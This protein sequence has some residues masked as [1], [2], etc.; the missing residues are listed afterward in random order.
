MRLWRWVKVVMGIAALLVAIAVAGVLF[1]READSKALA[2]LEAEI[3]QRGHPVTLDELAAR[4]PPIPEERNA[5][6]ALMDLWQRNDPVFWRAFRTGATQLPKDHTNTWDPS[7]PFLGAG[8]LRIPRSTVMDPDARRAA[9]VF[10]SEDPSRLAEVRAALARPECRFPVILTNGFGAL[11]PHLKSIRTEA[12]RLRIGVAVATDD[13]H[14]AMALDGMET[15][16]R[17]A[18]HLAGEPF[19][20]NQLVRIALLDGI[21]DDASRLLSHCDLDSDQL[22]TLAKVLGRIDIGGAL[23]DALIAEVPQGV[24]LFAPTMES[25]YGSPLL[26]GWVLDAI[27][28]KGAD[29]RLYLE[30]LLELTR[31]ATNASHS[32]VAEFERVARSAA[33]TA[34]SKVPNWVVS[35]MLLKPLAQLP[36]IFV[37]LEARHRAAFVALA[38]ER[39]RLAQHGELPESLAEFSKELLPAIP[40]DPFDG[41]PL[42]YRRRGR[43]YVLYSVGSDLQ[44]DNGKEPDSK[45]SS[46]KETSD[47]TFI[48]ER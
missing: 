45:T 6:E 13:C 4:H 38:L 16:T 11:M 27:G 34:W 17:L 21:L 47:Q 33:E 5:A 44:D 22:E 23:E 37:G 48:V 15:T 43:G 1:W 46:K 32:A 8:M 19:L 18:G 35:G 31:L 39:H 24:S 40:T 7:L 28:S 9:E 26:G 2:R 29:R 25:P 10:L 30:T 12:S 36:P 41:N 20:I 3:R 42:R 14:A